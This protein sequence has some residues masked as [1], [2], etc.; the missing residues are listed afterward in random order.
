MHLREEDRV[1][2][3]VEGF[4]KIQEDGVYLARL[5][6]TV[7]EVTKCVDELSFA[8]PALAKAV[9]EVRKN[10]IVVKMVDYG[11]IDDVFQEFAD[12]TGQ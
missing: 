2:N 7:G 5:V 4:G 8:A 12:N 6:E 9:L 1:V 3:L 11:A 10:V